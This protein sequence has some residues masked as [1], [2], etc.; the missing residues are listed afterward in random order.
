MEANE[1]KAPAS[2]QGKA[3]AMRADYIAKHFADEE[4]HMEKPGY[5]GLRGH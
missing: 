5:P 4:W 2:E 3:F 1:S